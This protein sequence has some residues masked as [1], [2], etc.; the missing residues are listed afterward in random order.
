MKRIRSVIIDDETANLEVLADMLNRHCPSIELVGFAKSAIEGFELIQNTQPGLVFLDIMMPDKT[1]FDLLRMFEEINFDIIF[2]SGFDRYAIQAF[3]FNALHYILKPIDYSKLIQAVS[4]VEEKL[5]RNDSHIIHLIHSLDEKNKLIKTIS[6]H[7]NDKV[8]VI[9][10][11][12]ICLIQSSGGYSEVITMNG[13]KF[14]SAKNLAEYEDLFKSY[15]NFLRV[16]RSVLINVDY[17]QEYT[18]GMFCFIR[19]KNHETEIEVSRR[20]KADIIR[21]L[22]AIGHKI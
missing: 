10:I 1:G 18:K 20:K 4:K 17:I 5:V 9:D 21:R 7:H 12:H 13:L 15:T 14:L 22:K 6:L 8:H 2:V 19:M 16:S 3:E 11:N